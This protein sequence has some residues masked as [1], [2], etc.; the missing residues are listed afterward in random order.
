MAT[1]A[2]SE[3][4]SICDQ[5]KTLLKERKYEEA[6]GLY[7]QALEKDPRNIPAHEGIAAAA[8]VLKDFDSA[9]THYKK[10]SMLDVRRAEPL[11][12]LGAVYNRMGDFATAARTLR[13]AISK[14]RK[15]AAAY[16]NLGIA[17][18]GQNQQSLAISAYKEAIRLDPTMAESHQNLGNV[19]F[20]MGN[21]QS[22]ILHHEKALELNPKFEK[23]RKGLEKARFA[24]DEA[25]RTQNPFGRLVDESEVSGRQQVAAYRELSA[26]ERFEDRQALHQMAKEA[27]Q[28]AVAVK[29][30][31]REELS[32]AILRLQQTSAQ[33][34]DARSLYRE[35]EQ[36]TRI[37]GRFCAV[38][39]AM[40][41]KTEA[42]RQHEKVV[43][44]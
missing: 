26:Q 30:Q 40:R 5:A 11:I 7:E 34:D 2:L 44:G 27:E 1:P 39:D 13:Q 14:D 22:A 15:S 33:Q 24:Q 31:I 43:R 20:D 19:Y 8:F 38:A 32:P 29:T 17:Y 28:L 10:L 18:K 36:I 25:K 16:Y 23:A 12:N 35:A 4:D 6:R 9:A 37:A 42:I 41:T 3:A 21:F